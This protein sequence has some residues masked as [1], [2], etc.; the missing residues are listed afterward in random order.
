MVLSKLYSNAL[1]SSLN[2]RAASVNERHS[3]QDLPQFT[4]VG[5]PVTIGADNV[6]WVNVKD[7]DSVRLWPSCDLR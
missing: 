5:I 2:S 4:S 1:L 6:E 3:M 7:T